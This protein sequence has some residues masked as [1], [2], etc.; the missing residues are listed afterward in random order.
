MK[1]PARKT[2]LAVLSVLMLLLVSLFAAACATTKQ[3]YTMTFETNGGTEI[4]PITAEAG[5]TVT[6]P[7]DP[8]KDGAVFDGWYTSADFS[9]ESVQIPTVMP[10][11]NVTYYAKFDETEMA[12]LTLNAGLG[13]LAQTEYDLEVGTDVFEFVSSLVPA[14]PEGLTFGGWFVGDSE[15]I[16]AAGTQ[17]PAAGLSLSA[18]Y[19][20]SYTVEVYLQNG[21][22][23][24]DYTLDASAGVEGGTD[25]VGETVDL[26]SELGSVQGYTINETLTQPIELGADAAQNVYKAYYDLRTYAVYYFDNAP[27]GAEVSGTMEDGTAYYGQDLVIPEPGFSV[28]GYRFA[29]WSKSASGAVAYAPGEEISVSGITILYA[30]WNR[31]LEDVNGG[32]DVLYV[33]QEEPGTILLVRDYMEPQKGSYDAALRTFWFGT[34]FSDNKL[35]RGRVS[36]D[37][38][39]Y[40]YYYE[41][42]AIPAY[43]QFD[44]VNGDI[45]SGV[46]LSLDGIDGATYT[47]AEGTAVEG[48]Y[49]PSGTDFLFVSDDETTSFYFTLAVSSD[50][51]DLFL[52]R[53]AYASAY[54]YYDASAGSL[55]LP[56][57]VLDGYG[58]ATYLAS[59]SSMLSGTYVTLPDN[60]VELT[61][62]N[63]QTGEEVIVVVRLA[64]VSASGQT[65]T[66]FTYA[67]TA[68]GEYSFRLDG[69]NRPGT[70]DVTLDGF[71]N[72]TYRFDPD[73]EGEAN[74]EGTAQYTYL[75]SYTRGGVTYGIFSFSLGSDESLTTYNVRFN[76]DT[77]E[78]ERVG[79]ESGFYSEYNATSGFTARLL[80][81]GDGTAALY[82]AMQNGS[83]AALVDGTYALKAGETDI[84][85]FT[86]TSYAESDTQ[87][88]EALLSDAY[89]A[90]TFCLYAEKGVFVLS[91]G[92]EGMYSFTMGTDESAVEWIMDC[93]GFAYATVMQNGAPAG[94]VYYTVIDAYGEY[95]FIRFGVSTMFGTM[96]Y[97]VRVIPGTA[98]AGVATPAEVFSGTYGVFS[99]YGDRMPGHTETM[100]LYPDGHATI[101]ILT[102]EETGAYLSIEGTYAADEELESIYVF[103]ADSVPEGYAAYASFRFFPAVISQSYYYFCYYDESEIASLTFRG[104]T[105]SLTGYGI[106]TLGQAQYRYY[107]ETA[108]DQT[109]LCL[110]SLMGG[111][112]YR[113]AYDPATQT[114][115]EEPGTE[116]GSYYS[117]LFDEENGRYVVGEYTV[118]LDGYGN[119]TLLALSESG[120]YETSQTGTYTAEGDV[121][122]V[123]WASGEFYDFLLS[124][125]T[126]NKT[127]VAIYIIGDPMLEVAYTVAG[128]NAVIERDQFGRITFT[129][130]DVSANANFATGELN[131]VNLLVVTVYD[132]E[133]NATAAYVY[134]MD[135]TT[136]TQTDG[137]V[138]TYAL[139]SG[140]RIYTTQTLVLDGFGGATLTQADGTQVR[141][142]YDAVADSVGEW[143]FR[144]EDGLAFTFTLTQV[145]TVD[146]TTSA[147]YIIYQQK[148]DAQFSASDWQLL[149]V[150]GYGGATLIDFYGRAYDV[151]YTALTDD[152]LHLYGS[153]FGDRYFRVDGTSFAEITDDFVVEDGVLLAYQGAGGAITIPDGVTSI[154][155]SVFYLQTNI[156]EV[157]L[158]DVET[159]GE[160]A[161]QANAILAFTGTENVR[162]IGAYAFYQSIYLK[163]VSFPNA[164]TVG[165]YAFARSTALEQ[166]SFGASLKSIGSSAFLECGSYR[167]AT[168]TL[169][170]AGTT[171][172]AM[173]ENVLQDAGTLGAFIAAPDTA[174]AAAFREAWSATYASYVGVTPSAAAAAVA[175][176]YYT[177]LG[178]SPAARLVLGA[179]V[180]LNGTTVGI[181]DVTGTTIT[182]TLFADNSTV[183]GT[184]SGDTGKTIA[185]TLN[186]NAYT[187]YAEGT[188]RT[189]TGTAGSV[190][191]ALGYGSTTGLYN[192]RSVEVTLD[193]GIYFIL[194]GYRH[195]LSIDLANGTF[196]EEVAFEAIVRDYVA[197]GTDDYN[198][199]LRIIEG[200]DAEGN[201]TYT[202]EKGNQNRLYSIDR[203]SYRTQVSNNRGN[204]TLA[205]IAQDGDILTYR[206]TIP[207]VAYYN[208]MP[209]SMTYSVI[210]IVDNGE[211]IGEDGEYA[212]LFYLE[213][214][215]HPAVAVDGLDA[216][217]QMTFVYEPVQYGTGAITSVEFT[218]GGT[219]VVSDE[220]TVNTEDTI[221]FTVN[222]GDYAGTYVL[223]VSGSSNTRINS[224]TYTASAQA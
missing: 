79:N 78:A 94:G 88:Y 77:D 41:E 83:Y 96:Y 118:T 28:E 81:Y 170:L 43:K 211:A 164:E 220:I 215:Y 112:M 153:T 16:L 19:T 99:D 33:L 58:S 189:L 113:I 17:L 57:I 60:I 196:T 67:D 14:A 168:F 111:L 10:A 210:A 157:N 197:Y 223:A 24:S 114:I 140:D 92:V 20:V 63:D 219:T 184:V 147:A 175:G 106:A 224:I 101:R 125:A 108:G 1:N 100:I 69:N 163:A 6:P 9:G 216:S 138:G 132:D 154:A 205:L 201:A 158:N 38:T 200:R 86:A 72:L 32:N 8:E 150:N 53:D 199:T 217:V 2:W 218:I 137:R 103:T 59:L 173:G 76:A 171:A 134:R 23:S 129:Q 123:R 179:Q 128:S 119:A 71:G 122:S 160:F 131:G 121:I 75:V 104:E 198:S 195:T 116:Q 203:R 152:I 89:G 193:D 31:G 180:V 187:F 45:V 97:Y 141:G 127:T 30:C 48:T 117:Y 190:T 3:T 139:L 130:D 161:F 174:A 44:W 61:F 188:E 22:E 222:A 142:K 183:S 169:T 212:F 4:A 66:V 178:V 74:V 144:S 68:R 51:E 39:T 95:S 21:P 162:T 5:A 213:E 29:G 182:V 64:A 42:Y 70:M 186:G 49:T 208:N 148:W 204:W 35:P 90:F 145:T 159:V 46:T 37:G 115:P 133:G 214:A 87:D 202:L 221:T 181:Y 65:Y 105:L 98:Q 166:V 207:F 124:S 107:F 13:T 73:A 146:G 143:T 80:M 136:L 172:P 167:D 192:D 54:Y 15:T 209:Y 85:T 52:V 55:G 25:Y 36:A 62:A 12:K 135:G 110:A 50:G 176:V 191:I 126:V 102:D 84:Y 82:F 56:I 165:E 93:N 120:S 34:D 7:A 11:E 27:E 40:A 177:D 206:I 109:Y 155:D 151:N 18:R 47:N 149:L 185:I 156:T 91:D 194:D 26:I